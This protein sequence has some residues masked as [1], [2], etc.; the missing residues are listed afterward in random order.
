M[1]SITE[2][3]NAHFFIDFAWEK[4]GHIRS[5]R[6]GLEEVF[7]GKYLETLYVPH[8][9]Q[10]FLL[11]GC[12]REKELGLLEVKEILAAAAAKCREWK[13]KECSVDISRFIDALGRDAVTQSVL[14]L[15][16]GS[17]SYSFSGKE[18]EGAPCRFQLER[19]SGL[20]DMEGLLAEAEELVRG[21]RFARD[22]VN[23]PGNHLRPMDFDRRITGFVQDVEIEAQTLVYG[24][25]RAMG[26]EALYGIGGSSEY[27]PC[28]LILRYRGNPESEEVYGLIGKGVTCDTGGYCLK[29]SKSMAGITGDMAG[30]AAAAGAMHAAAAAKLKVNVTACLPLCENRISQSAFLPGDVI[31]GYGGKTI[32]ILNTDAEGR[33]VLSDAVSYGI[34]EENITRIVDIATLTGAVWNA[35]GYTI[36]GSMSDDDSFYRMFEKGLVHSTEKYLRFPF[37]REHRKMIQSDVADIKN[38]GADCCGSITAGLFIREFCEG[39]PWIHLDIAGTAWCDTPSFAFESKGATGAGVTS[40]YFMLKEA[41]GSAGEGLR[42]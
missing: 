33:L 27:P 9:G 21:I 31:T 37:G 5:Y 24:Q 6:L 17:Y 34:R 38:I 20:E 23:T 18:E 13:V 32:E 42:A 1:V 41:A 36:A 10:A 7:E 16:L 40:L 28:L 35:L 4:D 29:G 30:A 25:L 39:K 8:P 22:M 15:E 12:G 26:M 3:K 11:V 14:G 19:V 2:G